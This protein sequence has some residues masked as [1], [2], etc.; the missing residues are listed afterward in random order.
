MGDNDAADVIRRAERVVLSA[1]W[2][3]QEQRVLRKLAGTRGLALARLDP[4]SE[5]I[6]LVTYDGEHLGHVRR[7]GRNG[8]AERWVAVTREQA[9]RIG[10]YESAAAA[11]A[12][13]ALAC[14]KMTAQR[15]GQEG[16]T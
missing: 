12:A 15:P 8:P 10:Q 9:R 11:A 14:G 13:L 3:L 5:V 1:G 16:S 2:Q 4:R 7:D 6:Q